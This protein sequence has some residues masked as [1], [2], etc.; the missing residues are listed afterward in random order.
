MIIK[1]TQEVNVALDNSQQKQV[2]LDYLLKQADWKSSYWI[3]DDGWVYENK[4]CHTT[5]SFE[6]KE[7][8]R[9]ANSEDKLIN[10]I[11]KN[12]FFNL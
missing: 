3:N 10:N 5:H 1:A 4:E 9:V 8:V 11:L 12:H 7:K 6:I 2:A